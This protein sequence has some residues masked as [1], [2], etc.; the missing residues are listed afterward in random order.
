VGGTAVAPVITYGEIVPYCV[1]C[2]RLHVVCRYTFCG[3]EDRTLA[4][5]ATRTPPGPPPREP[6]VAPLLSDIGCDVCG[7]WECAGCESLELMAG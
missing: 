4:G 1:F 2:G 6:G 7:E 5:M 3:G